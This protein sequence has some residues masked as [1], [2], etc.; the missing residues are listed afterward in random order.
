M[1]DTDVS[2]EFGEEPG[3]SCLVFGPDGSHILHYHKNSFE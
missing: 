1:A 3:F 2:H